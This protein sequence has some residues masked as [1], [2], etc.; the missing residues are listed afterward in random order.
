MFYFII[1]I[2]LSF[3][4]SEQVD[5]FA[6]KAQS[7]NFLSL[8]TLPRDHGTCHSL[9]EDSLSLSHYIPTTYGLAI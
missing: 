5:T 7:I 9:E 3:F 8:D 1:I 4:F 2:F 6:D